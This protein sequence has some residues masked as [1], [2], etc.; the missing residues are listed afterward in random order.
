MNYLLEV[1]LVAFTLATNLAPSA[2]AQ[3]PANEPM[4]TGISVQMASSKNALPVPDADKANAW[5]VTLSNTGGVYFGEGQLTFDGLR[6]EMISHP[7]NRDQKLYIKADARAQYADVERVL[8]A[9]RASDFFTPV[10]LTAQTEEHALGTPIPPTGMELSVGSTTTA[11]S[12]SM[13]VQILN[14]SPGQQALK[15]NNE[16]IPWADLQDR[17]RESL[18][19]QREPVVV[20]TAGGGLPFAAVVHV[21]DVCRQAGAKVIL[22]TPAL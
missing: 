15:M 21:I 11:R 19:K 17:M 20:V 7:R 3:S 13:A 6:Q 9:A 22:A 18:G 1:C 5:V 16:Q 8:M 14:S 2:A 12:G 4:Q 10:L